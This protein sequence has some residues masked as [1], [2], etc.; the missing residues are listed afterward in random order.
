MG[1]CEPIQSTVNAEGGDDLVFGQMANTALLPPGTLW[2][3]VYLTRITQ[4]RDRPAPANS[5]LPRFTC[6]AR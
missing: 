6:P 3:P 1:C 4:I 5:T 2:T